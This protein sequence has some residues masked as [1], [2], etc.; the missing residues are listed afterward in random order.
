MSARRRRVGT[1]LYQISEADTSGSYD[2]HEGK[3]KSYSQFSGNKNIKDN[4]FDFEFEVMA[5]RDR[6]KEFSNTIQN[7]QSRQISTVNAIRDPKKSVYVQSHAQFM[8][9]A[10]SIGKNIAN[11]YSKLEKLTLCK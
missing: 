2:K 6:T 10:R 8:L 7:L 1:E 4:N 11:T 5:C 3:L 9:I